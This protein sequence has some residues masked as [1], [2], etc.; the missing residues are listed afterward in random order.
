M[1]INKEGG[2]I[3]DDEGDD[4]QYKGGEIWDIPSMSSPA[5]VTIG[6]KH[7]QNTKESASS[8]KQVTICATNTHKSMDT[9]TRNNWEEDNGGGKGDDYIASTCLLAQTKPKL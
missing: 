7:T 2:Q 4:D 9:N 1:I 8:P 6:N 5:Q 3:D